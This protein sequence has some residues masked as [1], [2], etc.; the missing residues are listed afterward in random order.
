MD[1]SEHSNGVPSFILGRG[2]VDPDQVISSV[3]QLAKAMFIKHR[4]AVVID[5]SELPPSIAVPGPCNGLALCCSTPST[6]PAS[7]PMKATTSSTPLSIPYTCCQKSGAPL[8]I[9]R[10]RWKRGRYITAAVVHRA[11]EAER[12]RPR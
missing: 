10:P 6:F 11:I 4:G 3:H 7:K 1:A 8:P 9:S 12:G 5:A 2:A